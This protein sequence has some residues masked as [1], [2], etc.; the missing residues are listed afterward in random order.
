MR[1]YFC[2]IFGHSFICL[3][4]HRWGYI[5]DD[6]N[7]MVSGTNEGSVTSGW[8]CQHCGKLRHEQWDT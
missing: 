3:F 1:K 2:W 8:I 6:P 7:F 4:W 5:V